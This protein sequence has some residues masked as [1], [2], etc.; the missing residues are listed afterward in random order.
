MIIE[1]L[2]NKLEDSGMGF[3]SRQEGVEPDV[4]AQNKAKKI[5]VPEKFKADIEALEKYAESGLESGLCITVSL[6]ELLSI[7]PRERRRTDAFSG[8]VNFLK[9]EMN[10]TLIIKSQKNNAL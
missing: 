3:F 8:L 7:C 2:T 1:S 9:E 5:I 6:S 4:I 10:V